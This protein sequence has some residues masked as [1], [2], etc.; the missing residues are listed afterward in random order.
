M[1]ISAFYVTQLQSPNILSIDYIAE[2]WQQCMLSNEY[3]QRQLA[4]KLATKSKYRPKSHL[5]DRDSEALSRSK[6]VFLP[7]CVE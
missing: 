5:Q 3:Q 7:Q 6:I 2:K 4:A 1:K